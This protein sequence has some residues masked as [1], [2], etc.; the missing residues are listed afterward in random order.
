MSDARWTDETWKRGPA[1]ADA[2]ASVASATGETDDDEPTYGQ[3]AELREQVAR[4]VGTLRRDE[5]TM[6]KH[7]PGVGGE[8]PGLIG[9]GY[10]ASIAGLLEH[11]LDTAAE[12]PQ[13]GVWSLPAEPGPEVMAVRDSF[14][15]VWCREG[16][17]GG[18]QGWT[19]KHYNQPESR[20]YPETFHLDWPDVVGGYG[21]LTDATEEVGRG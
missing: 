14:G 10:L 1:L 8:E 19:A 21:P 2:S 6:Q 16:V 15:I 5:A 3:L 20:T 17:A 9:W 7:R 12:S 18:W 11:A 4:V 13:P